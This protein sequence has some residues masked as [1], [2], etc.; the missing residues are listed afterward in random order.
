M[1]GCSSAFLWVSYA[2][3]TQWL[4]LC[5]ETLQLLKG[6]IK[7]ASFWAAEIILIKCAVDPC[8]IAEKWWH[9]KK[10]FLV[11]CRISSLSLSIKVPFVIHPTHVVILITRGGKLLHSSVKAN[12]CCKEPQQLF[13]HNWSP[14]HKRFTLTHRALKDLH[15]ICL[16]GLKEMKEW[17]S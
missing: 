14:Y 10:Y 5:I 16:K 13:T 4:Y 8:E 12:P 17:V 11:K 3:M 15:L 6:E 1:R 7:E 9:R 2:Y